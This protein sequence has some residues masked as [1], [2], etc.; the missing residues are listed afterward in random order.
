MMSVLSS[1]LFY[2]PT[3]VVAMHSH[4]YNQL[5]NIRSILIQK[6]RSMI[7][8]K[9]MSNISLVD[10]LE[11]YSQYLDSRFSG[12]FCVFHRQLLV[13]LD[14]DNFGKRNMRKIFFL[15]SLLRRN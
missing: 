8:L 9:K 14:V 3:D 11:H 12:Y 5:P 2:I 6:D 13:I 10:R 15:I 1:I 4:K 7:E